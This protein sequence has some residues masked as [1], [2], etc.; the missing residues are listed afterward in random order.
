M[1]RTLFLKNHPLVTF[2]SK[3]DGSFAI[4]KIHEADFSLWP[5]LLQKNHT[6][7]YLKE[8]LTKRVSPVG[9]K[10]LQKIKEASKLEGLIG[11]VALTKGL[12]LNDNFW[13]GRESE[14]FEDV[15]LYKN[16]FSEEIAELAFSPTS[17]KIIALASRSPEYA[18][19]GAMRK[20]WIRRDETIYLMK[21]DDW[22]NQG[23]Y[24]QVFA[25]YFASQLAK[26]FG[27]EAVPYFLESRINRKGQEEIV[28]LCPIFTSIEKS[29]LSAKDYFLYHGLKESDLLPSWLEN[30]IYHENLVKYYSRE[31]YED[32][33]VFDVI[34][35]NQDRHLNNFGYFFDGTNCKILS[36]AP[37]FDHGFSLLAGVITRED[38]TLEECLLEANRGAF[39]DFSTQLKYFLKARH[40]PKLKKL[41]DFAIQQHPV[42]KISEQ[43]FE[44]IQLYLTF[45]LKKAL[46]QAER[47][48]AKADA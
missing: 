20:C 12:S 45:W 18:S 7:P 11:Q 15:N 32:M 44:K 47:L 29:F 40:Y 6:A 37:L 1:E 31:I 9:R 48:L 16:S 14:R 42:Y 35:G 5:H 38:L 25:E 22:P 2:S 39:L 26:A 4:K 17:R 13:I 36:P 8:W 30:A 33:M 34:I 23:N 46:Y 28:C 3:A 19:D 24:N 21:A 10:L 43:S 27:I 41:A